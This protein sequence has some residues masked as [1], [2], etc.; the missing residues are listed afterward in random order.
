[1]SFGHFSIF[2]AYAAGAQ[3]DFRRLLRNSGEALL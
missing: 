2:I 1:M 3:E